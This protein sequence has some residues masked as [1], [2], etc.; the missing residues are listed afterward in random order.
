MSQPVSTKAMVN[1]RE[2]KVTLVPVQ[3]GNCELVFMF[4]GDARPHGVCI[5]REDAY[6]LGKALL[7]ASGNVRS[8]A[9]FPPRSM[10]EILAA[11]QAER[12]RCRELVA[13]HLLMPDEI[14]H[15]IY[16][17]TMGRAGKAMASTRP[18]T[19]VGGVT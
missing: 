6:K 7:D 14:A 9:K 8:N 15:D 1:G 18:S 5:R 10:A 4:D 12:E 16:T 17:L 3:S 19:K 13:S 11:E 2:V